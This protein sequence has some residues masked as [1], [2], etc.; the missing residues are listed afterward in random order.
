MV[1]AREPLFLPFRALGYIT[2]HVPFAVQRLGRET[3]VTVSVGK[4]WQVRCYAVYEEERLPAC[5]RRLLQS[6]CFV[7][8]ACSHEK[9]C[10]VTDTATTAVGQLCVHSKRGYVCAGLQ[11]R[12]AAAHPCRAPGA[13][14]SL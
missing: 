6:L 4:A 1:E 10:R 5:P 8:Q 14:P 3:Y 2:D 13:K 7:T 11:L 9:L 12:T